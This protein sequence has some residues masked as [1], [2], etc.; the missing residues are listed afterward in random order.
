MCQA[1]PGP[2]CASHTGNELKDAKE[3]QHHVEK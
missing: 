3:F 1:K 2:R